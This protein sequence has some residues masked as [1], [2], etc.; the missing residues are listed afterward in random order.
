M[1][2]IAQKHTVTLT[3]DVDPDWIAFCV[4]PDTDLFRSGYCGYWLR[5]VERTKARG[6]LV[7]E[8]DEQHAFGEEPGRK[9]ALRAWRKGE[10]L[11]NGWHR[12]DLAFAV[13]AWGVAVLTFGEKW[14]DEGDAD[15]YDYVVQQALLGEQRYA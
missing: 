4:G 3:S 5:G 8:D 12:M 10:A 13:K 6:R 14:Y 7:W 9:E 11:P 2:T 15:R 1:M